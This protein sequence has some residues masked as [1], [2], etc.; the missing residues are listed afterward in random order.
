MQ[1]EKVSALQA[2]GF[3]VATNVRMRYLTPDATG[4]A[5]RITVQDNQ[6]PT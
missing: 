3:I 4:W 5:V 2:A 6:G 1:A